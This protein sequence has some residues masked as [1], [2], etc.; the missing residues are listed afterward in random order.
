[1]NLL[2]NFELFVEN[3]PK[4]AQKRFLAFLSLITLNE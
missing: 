1:M 4:F 3:G 2:A